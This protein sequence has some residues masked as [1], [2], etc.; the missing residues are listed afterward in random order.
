MKT[1]LVIGALC[2]AL[3]LPADAASPPNREV[4]RL[5][6]QVALLKKEN[7]RLTLSNIL[8]TGFTQEVVGVL[9]HRIGLGD[10]CPLTVPNLMP[11][12]GSMFGVPHGNGKLWAGVWASNIVFQKPQADGWI[13]AKFGWFRAVPGQLTIE[14]HRLDGAAPPAR[15][16]VP[17]GYGDR[18]FQASGV[19]FPT[20]GCWQVTGHVGTVSLTFVTIVLKRPDV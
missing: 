1:V 12:P 18:G 15:S 5:K 8:S 7:R 20:E 14:A 2:A 3:A 6:H 9:M 4:T 11:P 16:S 13:D 10:K 17:F 19:I